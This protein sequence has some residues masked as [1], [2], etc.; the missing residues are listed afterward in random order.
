MGTCFTEMMADVTKATCQ[1]QSEMTKT[2]ATKLRKSV[3]QWSVDPTVV[4]G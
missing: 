3:V 4:S 1:D 2:G